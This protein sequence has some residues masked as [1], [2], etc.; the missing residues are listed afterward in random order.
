MIEQRRKKSAIFFALTWLIFA[1]PVTY[2]NHISHTLIIPLSY[3]YTCSFLDKIL[4]IILFYLVLGCI[5]ITS[6]NG[7][8]TIKYS[9]V[10]QFLY[11]IST[12]LYEAKACLSIMC[13]VCY[14]SLCVII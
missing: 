3:L 5:I 2:V 9:S 7:L 8:R 11:C 12:L 1:G 14:L 13:T 4:A 10:S 6:S